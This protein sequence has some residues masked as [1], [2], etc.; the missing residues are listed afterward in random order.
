MQNGSLLA[1]WATDADIRFIYASSAA[2]YGAG[3]KGYIE[4]NFKELIPLNM[5]AY[6]NQLFDL[7]ADKNKMLDKVAGLKYFNVFGPNEYHK[8][9]MRHPPGWCLLPAR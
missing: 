7:W 9:D 1:Q 3:E 4:D 8:D 6:S 2:T 5:Y